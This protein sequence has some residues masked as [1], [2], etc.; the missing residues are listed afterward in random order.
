MSHFRT[1]YLAAFAVRI[2]IVFILIPLAK[3]VNE[4]FYCFV[5]RTYHWLLQTLLHSVCDS[6]SSTLGSLAGASMFDIVPFM[7]KII[8]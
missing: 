1:L 5:R 6:I 3:F 2:R 7:M 4:N 8:S